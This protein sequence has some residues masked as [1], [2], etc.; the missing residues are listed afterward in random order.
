MRESNRIGLLLGV[1]QRE[2]VAET[3][4]VASIDV[5]IRY[6]QSVHCTSTPLHPPISVHLTSRPAAA[7][8]CPGDDD[9]N[10]SHQ[11]ISR[12]THYCTVFCHLLASLFRQN[13]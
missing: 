11:S 8:G 3:A 13:A 6:S 7:D 10:K 12:F 5:I 4:C 1:M 9:A 2:T